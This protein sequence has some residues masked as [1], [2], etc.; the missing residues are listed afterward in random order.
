MLQCPGC[1]IRYFFTDPVEKKKKNYQTW[2][3]YK[4]FKRTGSHTLT[5]DFLRCSHISCKNPSYSKHVLPDH[6]L[7]FT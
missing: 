1:G 2:L 4:L 3:K 7:P 6:D 5:K